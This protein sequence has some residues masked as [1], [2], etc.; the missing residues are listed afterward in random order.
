MRAR[1]RIL[2]SP[3]N[4]LYSCSDLIIIVSDFI[5]IINRL[6]RWCWRKWEREANWEMGFCHEI[7][8]NEFGWWPAILIWCNSLAQP[9]IQ[10]PNTRTQSLRDVPQRLWFNTFR[11]TLEFKSPRDLLDFQLQMTRFHSVCM[12]CCDAPAEVTPPWNLKL[13]A[14]NGSTTGTMAD[15]IVFV[16]C[17]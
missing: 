7:E 13:Y 15:R 2:N 17:K 5:W 10:I 8:R 9:R 14:H 11:L 1:T 3:P 16:L 6:R 4:T 12:C